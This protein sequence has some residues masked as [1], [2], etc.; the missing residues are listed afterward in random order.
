MSKV[1]Q[2]FASPTQTFRRS[3]AGWIDVAWAVALLALG[4]LIAIFDETIG[5]ERVARLLFG[6]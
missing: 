1:V 4:M 5:L 3:F 2:V 6:A